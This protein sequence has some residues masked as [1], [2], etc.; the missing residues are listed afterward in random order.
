ME[1]VEGKYQLVKPSAEFTLSFHLM[2]IPQNQ[3]RTKLGKFCI[4]KDVIW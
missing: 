4:V 1:G 2:A 3:W